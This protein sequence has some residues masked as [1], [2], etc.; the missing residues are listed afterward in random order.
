MIKRLFFIAL[1]LLMAFCFWQYKELS[2]SQTASPKVSE[3]ALIS[4]QTSTKR[5][6]A[7][8]A[9]KVKSKGP[10]AGLI[11]QARLQQLHQQLQQS[12]SR[13]A[14]FDRPL[15]LNEH[16]DFSPT[17]ALV[18]YF[19]YF[20]S[21]RSEFSEPDLLLL[22]NADVHAQYPKHYW[23]PMLDL[24]MRFLSYKDAS[25]N[26]VNALSEHDAFYFQ[27]QPSAY[28]EQL[29]A[30]QLQYFSSKEQA[31]LFTQ[32]ETIMLQSSHAHKSDAQYQRYQER[33]EL[34][35][36]IYGEQA[37]ARLEQNQEKRRLWR[38][39]LSNYRLQR[40]ALLS[41]RSIDD[42][43]KQQALQQLL[44]DNFDNREQR[45]VRALERAG[46]L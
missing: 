24:F 38:V 37:A 11:D 28:H 35:T 29:Q 43:S 21:L 13:G 23:Q 6:A 1:C 32:H 3:L 34:A 17:A 7:N 15:V 8:L 10:A 42:L 12:S 39:K 20:Y 14:A 16:Q 40:D 25:A 18:F 26:W 33:P 22:F 31:A 36:E 9:P 41:N 45:R 2:H 4:T 44:D 30:L 19:N 27:Q 5:H 46:A